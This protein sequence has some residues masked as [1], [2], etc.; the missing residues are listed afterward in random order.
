MSGSALYQLQ[1]ILPLLPIREGSAPE[2]L[3]VMDAMRRG[4]YIGS[5]REGGWSATFATIV[6]IERV[7]AHGWEALELEGDAQLLY[8]TPHEYC[9]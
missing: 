5:V 7:T 9:R 1:V 8:P 2:R 3:H 6:D 4:T